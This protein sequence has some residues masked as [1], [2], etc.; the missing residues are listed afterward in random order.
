MNNQELYNNAKMTVIEHLMSGDKPIVLYGTGGNGKTYLV[1]EISE[2][3]DTNNYNVIHEILKPIEKMSNNDL[4]V[5]T[6]FNNLS[7]IDKESY[8]LVDMNNIRF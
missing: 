7:D 8:N 5:A 4:V 1:N 6:D 2:I 3:I